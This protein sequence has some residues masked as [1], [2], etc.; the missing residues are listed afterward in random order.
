MVGTHFK[1]K[2]RLRAVD[3]NASPIA[4]G[5]QTRTMAFVTISN[6]LSLTALDLGSGLVKNCIA[7]SSRHLTTAFVRLS[8][9][10]PGLMFNFLNVI[11]LQHQPV[12]IG[13]ETKKPSEGFEVAKLQM[14][15]WQAAHWAFLRTL[16]QTQQ[17]NE[18]MRTL[19]GQVEEQNPATTKEV[20]VD[21]QFSQQPESQLFVE[22]L[23]QAE[24]IETEPS[25]NDS[26][27]NLPEF[28]P[29]I[30]INGHEW[31][32]TI[33]TF[34]NSRVQFYEKKALGS[35]KDTKEIYKLV[36][37]LQ[38]L[39]HQ[40]AFKPEFLARRLSGNVGS[41]LLPFNRLVGPDDLGDTFCCT[42]NKPARHFRILQEFQA[43]YV[44]YAVGS[45]GTQ[46]RGLLSVSSSSLTATSRE[47][48]E[49]VLSLP[50]DSG[51]I[52]QGLTVFKVDGDLD[53]CKNGQSQT[54]VY[55]LELKLV[56]IVPT[57]KDPTS[58]LIRRFHFINSKRATTEDPGEIGGQHTKAHKPK[59]KG[60]VS[61]HP[62]YRA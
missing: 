32:L 11:G 16:I 51:S 53:A 45:S 52:N 37:A 41:T 3:L 20:E 5:T 62:V 6:P 1:V 29:G 10:L 14:G 2:S 13:I 23:L 31:W 55:T 18:K 43:P 42:N 17:E 12:A 39:R 59:T 26:Q 15:V 40:T 60:G 21:E 44:P 61:L 27:F 36:C 46:G 34:E 4:V 35:T 38:V 50:S 22:S 33:S 8:S 57:S 7:P 30:I 9:Q 56:M 54:F 49:G 48:T 19:R 24:E 47:Q 58:S 25:N 28:L